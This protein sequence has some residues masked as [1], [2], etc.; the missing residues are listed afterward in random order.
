MSFKA[1]KSWLIHIATSIPHN[2][3]RTSKVWRDAPITHACI[4][5]KNP[6]WSHLFSKALLQSFNPNSATRSHVAHCYLTGLNRVILETRRCGAELR[7]DHS[8][9]RLRENGGLIQGAN[10]TSASQTTQQTNATAGK[11]AG[12]V[13]L[14]PSF[15]SGGCMW[16]G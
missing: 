13:L 1:S 3:Q 4:E 16:D 6:H 14:K 10:G 15:L 8:C 12:F 5:I 2:T 7:G 11:L 9:P